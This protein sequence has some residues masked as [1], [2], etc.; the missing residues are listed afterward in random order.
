M[1]FLTNFVNRLI[2]VT[3]SGIES[4]SLVLIKHCHVATDCGVGVV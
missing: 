1:L 2:I 3:L 4:A